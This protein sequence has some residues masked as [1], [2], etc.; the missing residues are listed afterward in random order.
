MPTNKF[1]CHIQRP[2][3]QSFKHFSVCL[4]FKKHAVVLV[5][6]FLPPPPPNLTRQELQVKANCCS[7]LLCSATSP[8]FLET[9]KKPLKYS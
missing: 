5:Y 2:P 9:S 6:V 3:F 4:H 7:A 1:S 8:H